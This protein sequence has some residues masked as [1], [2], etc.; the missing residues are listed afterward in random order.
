MKELQRATGLRVAFS[1][2]T[3]TKTSVFAQSLQNKVPE[4]TVFV[5][6]QQ[7]DEIPKV[8]YQVIFWFDRR[9]KV[10]VERGWLT[11][12]D[13]TAT[14]R[15][16]DTPANG[17]M[18]KDFFRRAIAQAEFPTHGEGSPTSLFMYG[19]IPGFKHE[20]KEFTDSLSKE[21]VDCLVELQQERSI[22]AELRL[23]QSDME[24]RKEFDN[25]LD[26]DVDQYQRMLVY[27]AEEKRTIHLLEDGS[28]C[29]YG[30]EDLDMISNF[31]VQDARSWSYDID[32]LLRIVNGSDIE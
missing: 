31:L 11:T 27:G 13:R 30:L 25:E 29:G 8:G 5:G 20:N 16:L 9:R 12:V 14:V 2:C 1:D 3:L 18:K 7:T 10:G 19:D 21:V 6:R 23:L 24:Q 26:A 32:Q 22:L 17:E 15:L 4:G 28:N